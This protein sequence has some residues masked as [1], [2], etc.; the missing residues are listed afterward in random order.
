VCKKRSSLYFLGV[1]NKCYRIPTPI[2]DAD[3]RIDV[4]EESL[5]GDGAL[6]I[7][8]TDQ[9]VQYTSEA[10]T[11]VLEECC[12]WINMDGKSCYHDEHFVKVLS[13]MF[14]TS[15]SN[16]LLPPPVEAFYG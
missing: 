16:I 11:V 9:V 3:F 7:F 12:N 8:S 10:L 13:A 15:A 2:M 6:E 4:L 5:R 14:N 1:V